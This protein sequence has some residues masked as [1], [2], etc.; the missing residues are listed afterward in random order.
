M[1]LVCSLTHSFRSL[2]QTLTTFLNS[3]YHLISPSLSLAPPLHNEKEIT[4]RKH[5]PFYPSTLILPIREPI[6]IS[7]MTISEEPGSFLLTSLRPLL[8]CVSYVTQLRNL[9]KCCLSSIFSPDFYQ[10]FFPQQRA[11][12]SHFANETITTK[13]KNQKTIFGPSLIFS[14]FLF[15]SS[16]SSQTF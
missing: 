4:I 8:L 15:P 6:F 13:N 10:V 5:I 2:C 12:Q 7:L 14:D 3:L 16:F 11:D 1:S 9:Q